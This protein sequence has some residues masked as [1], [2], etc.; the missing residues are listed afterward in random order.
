MLSDI[1]VQPYIDKLADKVASEID[2]KDVIEAFRTI[3]RH[4]FVQHGF[5]IHDKLAHQMKF[6]TQDE[7]E[8]SDWL[9]II[10]DNQVLLLSLGDSDPPSS[11]SEPVLMAQMLDALQVKAGMNILEIGTGSGY[12]AALLAHLVGKTGKVT[13]IDIQPKLTQNAQDVIQTLADNVSVHTGNGLL[14]VSQNAPYDRIIATVSHHRVPDAWIEQL[15]DGGL[16]LM[17]FEKT[18]GLLLLE[19]Q[20][21]SVSGHFLQQQGYFMS[22][23]ESRENPEMFVQVADLD[24]LLSN[25][26]RFFA[27]W[28]IPFTFIAPIELSSDE[29]SSDNEGVRISSR[30]GLQ[31][32]SLKADDDQIKLIQQGSDEFVQSILDVIQRWDALGHPDSSK[33]RFIIDSNN[34]QVITIDGQKLI[35]L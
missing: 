23:V 3:P 25:D 7:T 34:Q 9:D 8:P 12:N 20:G 17:S 6:I 13:T 32:V 29:A 21:A 31:S 27:W 10:Y 30:D 28:F 2:D 26:F 35:E 15:R 19:K 14:G 4:L 5:Y 1:N 33:F 16:L 11:S 18:G 22:I 24:S